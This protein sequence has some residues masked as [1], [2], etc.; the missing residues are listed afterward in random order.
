MNVELPPGERS[1]DRPLESQVWQAL[2]GLIPAGDL[3]QEEKVRVVRYLRRRGWSDRR[4]AAWTRW[5]PDGDLD[6]GANAVCRFRTGAG[7]DGAV[8]ASVDMGL[9]IVSA[10]A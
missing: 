2:L 1:A 5:N 6:K 4:I 7:I 9:F 8:L 3:L 10:A